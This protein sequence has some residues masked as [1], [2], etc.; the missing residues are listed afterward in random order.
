MDKNRSQMDRRT[1]MISMAA[2]GSTMFLGN[3]FGQSA[4]RP[5][6]QMSGVLNARSIQRFAREIEKNRGKIIALD[7]S[8]DEAE[9]PG[10]AF[11]IGP[12]AGP[13]LII[14]Y[15]TAQIATTINV[16]GPY[17]KTSNNPNRY[18]F[19]GYYEVRTVAS[20]NS[21]NTRTYVLGRMP[22]AKVLDDGGVPKIRL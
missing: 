16:T 3:A 7:V 12:A 2:G 9:E 20:G 17:R 19:S 21:R 14:E 6:V 11:D 10:K 4:E 22:D 8:G 18:T 5:A 15:R 13:E 1:V